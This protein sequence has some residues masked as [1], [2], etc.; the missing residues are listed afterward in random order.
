[1][2]VEATYTTATQNHA[3]M[4]PHSAVAVWDDGELTIYSGNQASN[5][6]AMELASA[7]EPGPDGRARGEPVRRRRVRR[8]GPHVRAGVPGR[9]GG[10][11]AR[12]GR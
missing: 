2:V 6:Q 4:E 5:L 9:G 7:L 1:M 11:G 12:T 10:P 8:Q 3:A